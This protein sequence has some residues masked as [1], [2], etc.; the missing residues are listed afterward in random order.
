MPIYGDQLAF[1]SE[2]FRNFDYFRMT[3]KVTASYSTRESLGK[4]RGVFQ[5]FKS[6]ELK[7]EEDT[8]NDVNVPTLWTRQKLEV[9]EYFI[10]KDD[11]LY[12]IVN[13]AEWLFE[14]GFNVY[15]LETV[16]GNTDKQEAFEHVDLGQNSY[17]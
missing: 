1:F 5:Y 11:E 4:V 14:G 9:G 7:R 17:D 16:I 8:L 15:I 3:P 2:Q 10:Q 6:G 13:P 12:R